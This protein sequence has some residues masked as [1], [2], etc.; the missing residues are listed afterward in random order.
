MKTR[1]EKIWDFSISP[2]TV[3]MLAAK[4]R[5]FSAAV[6]DDYDSGHE[7]E[8]E[9]SDQATDAHSHDG[10]QEEEEE[11]LTEEEFRELVA[12]LNVDEAAELLAIAWIGRGDYDRQEWN[13]AVTGAQQ[14][15]NQRLAGYLL[16]MPMLSDWLEE[17]LE[18]LGA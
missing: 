12:D 13:E 10:L 14:R 16:S 15:V 11:N 4:A 17:G 2:D 8:I 1:K 3:R 18:E 7:H 5:A 9:F 6:N